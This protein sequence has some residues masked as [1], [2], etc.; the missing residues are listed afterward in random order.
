MDFQDMKS[1]QNPEIELNNIL[2]HGMC[3]KKIEVEAE[4]INLLINCIAQHQN[5]ITNMQ[6][7]IKLLTK[8]INDL[9][10]LINGE[11]EKDQ[12]EIAL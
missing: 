9:V 3:T 10:S 2:N 7:D 12:E 6:N 1:A 11:D 5:R 4:H 8:H